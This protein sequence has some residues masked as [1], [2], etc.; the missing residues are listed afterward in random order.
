MQIESQIEKKNQQQ[1]KRVEIFA[2]KSK[3]KEI[4]LGTLKR[5]PKML[6]CALALQQ[7]AI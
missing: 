6:S 1:Q 4:Q 3:R 7:Y 2:I 5:V